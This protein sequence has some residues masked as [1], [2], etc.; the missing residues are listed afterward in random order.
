[1]KRTQRGGTRRTAPLRETDI[2]RKGYF[3]SYYPPKGL[4]KTTGWRRMTLNAARRE[5]R[6]AQRTRKVPRRL[7]ALPSSRTKGHTEVDERT[8]VRRKRCVGL[9]SG[10]AVV[11]RPGTARLARLRQRN[12]RAWKGV[13]RIARDPSERTPHIASGSVDHSPFFYPL[14][15]RLLNLGVFPLVCSIITDGF[16]DLL[17]SSEMCSFTREMATEGERCVRGFIGKRRKS[18]P[19]R[20]DSDRS[21]EV[22]LLSCKGRT[23]GRAR[24]RAYH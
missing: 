7:R 10:D 4:D 13:R 14:Y 12:R 11:R 24:L 17:R 23:R 8:R 20:G 5:A 16:R 22:R 1:M 3:S 19:F 6:L 15:N 9:A 2:T 21:Q 18:G